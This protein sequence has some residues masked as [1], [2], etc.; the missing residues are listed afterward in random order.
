MSD[1]IEGATDIGDNHMTKWYGWHPDRVLNP[2]V[3]HLPDVEE[4]GLAIVHL[5]PNGLPCQSLIHLDGP[6]QQE[7][8]RS[9]QIWQRDSAEGEPLTV[10][11]SIQCGHCSDHGFIRQGKWVKA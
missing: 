1:E 3:A 10:S 8:L 6:V 5:T 4:F 9:S 7:I 11:P 2:H